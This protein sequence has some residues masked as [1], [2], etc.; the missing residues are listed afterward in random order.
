MVGFRGKAKQTMSNCLL[1]IV[2]AV[3]L[4]VSTGLPGP[5]SFH[6]GAIY[7]G[8]RRL[9][10]RIVQSLNSKMQAGEAQVGLIF[11]ESVAAHLLSYTDGMTMTNNTTG[12]LNTT[13][14]SSNPGG[15]SNLSA[16]MYDCAYLNRPVSWNT[17]SDSTRIDRG[18]KCA[19]GNPIAGP[20]TTGC[21]QNGVI[22]EH[23]SI[24]SSLGDRT[25]DPD[26]K[27]VII[28]ISGAHDNQ[29]YIPPDP[30][31][32]TYEFFDPNNI[33]PGLTGTSAS[34]TIGCLQQ[35]N[36][37]TSYNNS[38]NFAP[39]G[40]DN[41]LVIGVVVGDKDINNLNPSLGGMTQ[42]NRDQI[43]STLD[44]I[45]CVQNGFTGNGDPLGFYANVYNSGNMSTIANAIKSEICQDMVRTYNCSG[46]NGVSGIL[47]WQCY[48][49]G[50][51]LGTYTA[52]SALQSGY[53]NALSECLTDC[54][55]PQAV[56]DDDIATGVPNFCEFVELC[57][58]GWFGEMGERLSP[59]SNFFTSQCRN[60]IT[61]TIITATQRC[62][63]SNSPIAVGDAWMYN[64]DQE[65]IVN[66]IP[67][68]C[69]PCNFGIRSTC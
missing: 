38:S 67:T 47:P 56:V 48:D 11:F 12:S 17:L 20:N 4:S 22:N 41:Q 64:A 26:F 5:N 69:A 63:G 23:I 44:A 13:P 16:N 9:L 45:T 7:E 6:G 34:G 51:G 46:I 33:W 27:K 15:L 55:E 59:D 65:Y 35:S 49:P 21:Y 10:E 61:N 3:D 40:P 30:N 31:N 68:Q 60:P 50:T 19:G 25:G 24:P 37:L 29:I 62:I 43:L 54:R 52:T 18:M 53:P 42:D 57:P 66:I 14:S 28:V 58:C 36:L 1:D 8:E 39:T 32:L 2:I